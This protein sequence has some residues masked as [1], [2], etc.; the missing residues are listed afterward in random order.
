MGKGALRFTPPVKPGLKSPAL[1][2]D[3]KHRVYVLKGG[4]P[5]AIEVKPGASD[6]RNTEILEGGLT[7]GM[8][9]LTD[10]KEPA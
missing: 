6:G 9:V 1:I 4:L 3:G 5:V 2:A 8:A 10:T 7:E